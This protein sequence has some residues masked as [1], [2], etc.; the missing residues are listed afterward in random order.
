[1]SITILYT[2]LR[3]VPST[4]ERRSVIGDRQLT[5]YQ[6]IEKALGQSLANEIGEDLRNNSREL[7]VSWYNKRTNDISEIGGVGTLDWLVRDDTVFS[8]SYENESTTQQQ[9]EESIQWTLKQEL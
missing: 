5:A 2:D 4:L 3:V 1:M 8:I 7:I 6:V 9:I